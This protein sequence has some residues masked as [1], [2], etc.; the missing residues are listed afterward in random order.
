MASV[1]SENGIQS[2][3]LYTRDQGMSCRLSINSTGRR[4][5]LWMSSK[6]LSSVYWGASSISIYLKV[7]IPF[8]TPFKV[9]PTS[10]KIQVH[11]LPLNVFMQVYVPENLWISSSA[12][13]GMKL[14]SEQRSGM[15]C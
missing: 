4:T 6:Y 2:S 15:E 12:T 14:E 3:T 9:A 7:R 8:N 11:V 13:C 10:C 1:Q 5:L